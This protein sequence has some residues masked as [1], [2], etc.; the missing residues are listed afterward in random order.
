MAFNFSV[1][2]VRALSAI[3]FV[4]I[5]LA[6]LLFNNWS[7]FALFLLIQI[8]CLYEYQKL[9]RV[10]FPSYNQISKV[11]QWGVLVVGLFMMTSL[12]PTDIILPA[13]ILQKLPP[14]Y[15]GIGLRWIGL[16]AMPVALVLML[17]ADVFT[18]KA[19]IRNISISFFGFIYISISLSL[20]YAMRGMFLNS[21]MSMFFPNIELMVPILVIVTVWV[22]DTM[23]Y[24][25]GSFIGRTPI[26][27]ISPKKTWEGTIAGV[28]LSVVILSTV[29]GQ[30]IP[31]STKYLY[32]ITIVASVMGNLG[33]LFESKL[34]R[35]A[36]VKD[37]GSMMPGHGGFL[38][39]FDSILFAGPFVWILLQ[40]IF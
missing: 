1:F 36:G 2:K 27:P 28:I 18:R 9:M 3:V 23:A 38:D 13:A 39:R 7:Y 34:K 19:D 37:S 8:G 25:V 14:A 17:V 4:F 40:F 10:I 31:I 16:K 32:M 24:I 22:N 35:L 11:H 26:S 21:A 30:F 6:G 12:A 15:Q 5:M 29:A 33:D 20:F